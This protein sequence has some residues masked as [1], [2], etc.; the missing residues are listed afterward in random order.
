MTDYSRPFYV[1]IQL[2]LSSSMLCFCS[3][4]FVVDPL[5][6]VWHCRPMWSKVSR[7]PVSESSQIFRTTR[8]M[9]T[10]DSRDSSVQYTDGPR[11]GPQEFDSREG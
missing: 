10:G 11:A 2:S 3:G 7:F 5:L 9:E 8:C 1:R 6:H 4:I